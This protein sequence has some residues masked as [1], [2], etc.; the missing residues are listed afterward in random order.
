[1]T[2][3]DRREC[4]EDFQACES[5]A[6]DILPLKARAVLFALVLLVSVGGEYCLSYSVVHDLIGPLPGEPWS[7]VPAVVALSGLIAVIAFALYKRA[8]PASLPVRL[9]NAL[10]G[11]IALGFVMGMGLMLAKLIA[12]NTG[13][14]GE[15]IALFAEAAAED[16]SFLTRIF[17]FIDGPFAFA[18]GFLTICNLYVAEYALT[19]LRDVLQEL[20]EIHARLD[21]SRAAMNE[22]E[23]CE[24]GLA[25]LETERSQVLRAL[26]PAGAQGYAHELAAMIAET[27]GSTE[28]WITAHQIRKKPPESVLRT[29]AETDIDIGKL[30][31]R[32]SAL[33]LDSKVIYA[34]FRGEEKS[35]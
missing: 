26:E 25:R 32:I 18:F 12:A 31:E 11:Y 24:R 4:D 22:L 17:E 34:A 5:R 7:P 33:N 3:A 29:D 10:A 13:S 8:R 1:M 14:G 16:V 6:A 21:Q 20:H 27:R 2:D 35:R 19:R 9:V 30:K 28:Q 15:T 23:E